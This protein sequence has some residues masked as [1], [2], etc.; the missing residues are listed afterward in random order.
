MNDIAPK[1]RPRAMSGTHMNDVGPTSYS[2]RAAASSGALRC[3]ADRSS[4]GTRTGCCDRMTF[5]TWTRPIDAVLVSFDQRANELSLVRVVMHRLD[6]ANHPVVVGNVNRAIVGDRRRAVSRKLGEQR[7]I[8]Q[9]ARENLARFGEEL[10]RR[11]GF[12]QSLDRLRRLVGRSLDLLGHAIEH[13]TQ[14]ADLV[15][16]ARD[17]A[18]RVLPERNAFRRAGELDERPRD[19]AAQ[20]PSDGRAEHRQQNG[21]HG[22]RADRCLWAREDRLHRRFERDEQRRSANHGR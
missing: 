17:H 10:L 9:R 18:F 8:G 22:E 13:G 15:A 6:A 21:D 20:N 12:R 4:R 14:S 19:L 2:K 3:N 11:D 7:L 16:A 1:A 5:G